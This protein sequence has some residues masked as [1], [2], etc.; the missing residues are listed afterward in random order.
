MNTTAGA[1][2]VKATIR[3]MKAYIK[4]QVKRDIF[5]GYSAADVAENRMEVAHYLNCGDDS[6]RSDFHG[7]SI[8]TPAI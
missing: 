1:T 2:Y 4:A 7:V 3:D 6:E 5:V 8:P